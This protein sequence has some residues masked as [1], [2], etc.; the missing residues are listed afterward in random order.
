MRGFNKAIIIG[1]VSRD[2]EMR[3]TLNKRAYVRFSVAVGYNW[4][5][6][7][8]EIKE[9]VDFI[10][11]VAWGPLAEFCGKYLKKGSGVLVEGRIQTGSYEAK[12]GTG[13]RYTTDILA[14]TI[15]FVGSKKDDG[16]GEG[17]EGNREPRDKGKGASVRDKGFNDEEFP[18][19]FSEIELGPDE[20]GLDAEIP[21]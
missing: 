7:N 1:N 16:G 5:D 21:F 10:P 11:V 20:G 17:Y 6:Q 9:N 2:P 13:K 12:D 4:K 8:G 14:S 15:Q 19:D 3:Y 18:T